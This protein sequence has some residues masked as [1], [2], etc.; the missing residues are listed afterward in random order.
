MKVCSSRQM[1]ASGGIS[2]SQRS[3]IRKDDMK[4]LFTERNFVKRF[5]RHRKSYSHKGIYGRVLIIAAS[6]GMAGAGLLAS[7]GAL[8]TGAGIV[9]LAVPESL[10][11]IVSGKIPEV[12]TKGLPEDTKGCLSIDSYEE[13]MR[14]VDQSTAMLMGPGLGTS[15][16]IFNLL[17]GLIKEYKNTLVID[18]DG[19]N[20]LSKNPAVLREGK[21]EIIITPHPGEMAR[22]LGIG[23]DEVQKDRI[24]LAKEF[25]KE[26]E[27][28][29]VLKGYHTVIATREGRVWIN[30]TGNPGMATAGSGDVLAGVITALAAQGLKP[31]HAAACG[32]YI[33]GLAG[34]KAAG[35][36]GQWGMTSTDIIRFIPYA[37]KDIVDI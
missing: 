9:V 25:A 21:G 26:Y 32:A 17:Y 4:S 6:K 22:L 35:G 23:T 29:V 20:A 5:F 31:Q 8:R 27:V 36:L 10:M 15:D 34:D 30:P 11:C 2:I 24:S 19:L 3:K 12:I 16:D 33:H 1:K 13:I 28:T 18:A 14:S 37:I 7:E